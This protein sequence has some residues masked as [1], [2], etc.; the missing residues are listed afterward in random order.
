MRRKQ[1]ILP[2]DTDSSRFER[3]R[4]GRVAAQLERASQ[5]R[6]PGV[7]VA[8]R[9][10]DSKA[11]RSGSA[12]GGRGSGA[13]ARFDLEARL[14][15]RA[16]GDSLRVLDADLGVVGSAASIARLAEVMAVWMEPAADASI[17][18]AESAGESVGE[19][20]GSLGGS[21]GSPRSPSPHRSAGA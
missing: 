2:T 9:D 3:A 11:S 18:P 19:W 15:G 6:L 13:Q 16:E 4:A 17:P 7:R 10:A 8:V 21:G 20:A 14:P 1:Q 5:Q 12:G